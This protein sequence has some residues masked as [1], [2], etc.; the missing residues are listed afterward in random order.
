MDRVWIFNR[1]CSASHVDKRYGLYF[2]REK[3]GGMGEHYGYPCYRC[4]IYFCYGYNTWFL[5]MENRKS[6]PIVVLF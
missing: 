6:V 4:G 5:G 1:G 2:G 3:F